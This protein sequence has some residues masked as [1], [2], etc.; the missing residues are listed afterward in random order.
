MEFPSLAEDYVIR[1]LLR[2]GRRPTRDEFVAARVRVDAIER[3][4]V[5]LDAVP[6]EEENRE[7]TT[8]RL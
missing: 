5:G 3:P 4:P 1:S 7:D 6:R 8:D 2:L